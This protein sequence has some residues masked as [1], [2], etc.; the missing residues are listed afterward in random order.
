MIQSLSYLPAMSQV[1]LQI[2]ISPSFILQQQPYESFP[3]AYDPGLGVLLYKQSLDPGG[4]PVQFV[5]PRVV[6]G[7]SVTADV[8]SAPGD[9]QVLVADGQIFLPILSM[10][11]SCTL[12]ITFSSPP[13]ATAGKVAK[14]KM[15]IDIV[16][17]PTGG[18]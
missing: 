12:E 1:P 17:R 6:D 16:V 3:V 18:G 2:R 8:V 4:P 13:T 15:K 14:T 10:Y 11:E 9:A 7:D 5:F